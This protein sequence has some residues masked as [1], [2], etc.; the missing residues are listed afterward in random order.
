MNPTLPDL[1]TICDQ[2]WTRMVLPTIELMERQEIFL[3]AKGTIAVIPPKTDDMPQP[4]VIFIE[5]VR[6]VPE[7]EKYTKVALSKARIS[8][9]HGLPT[10]YIQ[11]RAPYLYQDGDT[12]WG[13]STVG[14]GGITV[15][16]SGQTEVFDQMIAEWML[17]G[18]TALYCTHMKDA[19]STDGAFLTIK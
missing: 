3:S 2:V 6:D 8:A 7:D 1:H 16:F 12:K 10:S 5:T 13:G 15:A 9:Q 19:L 18:I 11:N 4:D 14:Y 17:S